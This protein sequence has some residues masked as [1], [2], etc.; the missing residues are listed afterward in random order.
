MKS[1]SHRVKLWLQPRSSSRKPQTF[2][3]N[4]GPTRGF[5]LCLNFISFGSRIYLSL[6]SPVFLFIKCL[7]FKARKSLILLS[8][9][10]EP[11]NFL[12]HPFLLGCVT[13]NS[14]SCL[15]LQLPRMLLPALNI[16]FVNI[17]IYN[18]TLL[19][20]YKLRICYYSI[21][22]RFTVQR[23]VILTPV[24]ARACR[25]ISPM[26]NRGNDITPVGA[27]SCYRKSLPTS[28]PFGA[29]FLLWTASSGEALS[30]IRKDAMRWGFQ[31]TASVT[32][33]FDSLLRRCLLPS[34]CPQTLAGQET[35]QNQLSWPVRLTE[36]ALWPA[37]SSAFLAIKKALPSVC[38][39][40][41][42][43][44]N[45][46]MAGLLILLNCIVTLNIETK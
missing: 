1:I 15:L 44:R 35:A 5:G 7:S 43:N 46:L 10:L 22:Q 21:S 23:T 28:Q 19:I 39:T 24:R 14:R 17:I 3:A 38:S 29:V 26:E 41:Q 25:D 9:K 27:M 31:S 6:I 36:L 33:K 20:K 18:L 4:K 42:H 30:N 40:P 45:G 34:C 2:V 37:C 11:I 16:S 32:T 8:G 13:S 12:C